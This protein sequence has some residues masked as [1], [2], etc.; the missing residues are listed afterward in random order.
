MQSAAAERPEDGWTRE[1]LETHLREEYSTFTWLLEPI[2]EHAGFEIATADY[3][4]VGTYA[5]YICVRTTI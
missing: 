1:E 5:C 2:I 3:G 4:T